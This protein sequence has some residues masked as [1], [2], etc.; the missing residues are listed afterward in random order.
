MSCSLLT[1]DLGWSHPSCLIVHPCS[2]LL[3]ILSTFISGSQNM[4]FNQFS[5]LTYSPSLSD[6]VQ[7]CFII[8]IKDY[9]SC[10]LVKVANWPQMALFIEVI[11]FVFVVNKLNL[12]AFK[13]E[14]TI[15][16]SKPSPLPVVLHTA[17]LFILGIASY[18]RHLR[19]NPGETFK[20]HSPFLS[21]LKELNSFFLELA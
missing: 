6:V 3:S 19:W 8:Q 11:V 16:F 10:C 4:I 13:L 2:H 14:C 12:S 17:Q 20:G 15:Q 9:F 1:K 7:P 18:Y 21:L 5:I